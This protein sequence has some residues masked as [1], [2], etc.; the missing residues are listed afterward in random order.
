MEQKSSDDG[1][2]FVHV[3]RRHPINHQQIQ[4]AEHA[5]RAIQA[6]EVIDLTEQPFARVVSVGAGDADRD[7]PQVQM[8][9]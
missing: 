2:R 6:M 3:Y 1:P 5:E 7:V 8:P 9:N 4:T